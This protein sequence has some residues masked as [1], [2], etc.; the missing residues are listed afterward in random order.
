[1]YKITA[2]FALFFLFN[3]MPALPARA[4][5]EQEY[6]TTNKEDVQAFE[7][8]FG[9]G[10]QEEDVY[11]T[12]R[13]L[14][15]ATGSLKPIHLA[16]S[17]ASVITAEDIE[18]LGATTLDEV[19]ETVPG[20]HVTPS[21]AHL[22]AIY[23]IR[24]IHTSLNPQVLVL[25]NGI[26]FTKT[27][28]GTRPAGFR[29][30][31]SMISRIEVI[32]G[33]GSALYG[34]DAFAG[35]LNIITK[36]RFEV[37]KGYAGIRASSLDG[38]NVW[39]QHGEQYY[40]WDI[41]I[42]VEYWRSGSNDERIIEA[43]LQTKLDQAFG[44][45]ASLA[46]GFV[47]T[48][49]E[50]YNMANFSKNRWTIR[51]WG[52]F[53]NDY[54]GGTGGVDAL[55]PESKIN[56]EQFLSDI[57]WHGGNIIEDFDFTAQAHYLYRREDIIYQMLPPG[58]TVLVGTDGNLFTSPTAG[59][60]TFTDG[61]FGSPVLIDNEVSFDFISKYNGMNQHAWRIAVGGKLQDEDAESS[62]NFG[63][64]VLSNKKILPRT[65]DGDLVD[66]T[67]T[68]AMFMSDQN[69]TILHVSL[70]DEWSFTQDWEL[71]TG[72]RYDHYSDFGETI[73]PRV[74]LVWETRY[75]L[76]S[77]FM[78][79]RAFRPPSFAESSVR[80]NPIVSGNPNLDPETI[81]T[82]EFSIDYRPVSS[83]KS[84]LS[85]FAYDVEGLIDYIA[86]PAPATTKTARNSIDQKGHGFE[87]ELE[88][89]LNPS[90]QLKGNFA[91]QDSEDKKN[92][93]VVADAPG[94]Q[95]YLNANWN[96]MP[97]WYLTMQY[98]WI[99]DRQRAIDDN[100]KEIKDNSFANVLIRKKN[101]TQNVDLAFSVRNIFN[102][103]IRE[104]ISP[105]IPNDL[106]MENRSF[107]TE[108]IY[109]Y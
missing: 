60:I 14:L 8:M 23:S 50:N 63:P 105:D 102:E 73:N 21:F 67:G 58:T 44:T 107:Y 52:W 65:V 9:Q 34:A 95:C 75:D 48:D 76:T 93:E 87:V 51:L 36:D 53:L 16:P 33:P 25:L 92:G 20:L 10:P 28:N 26:P 89:E 98:F 54:E 5:S 46:P 62:K 80:N 12:D 68:D 109:H 88:W 3:N 35:T 79:G 2:T 72:L 39:A 38:M 82:Y 61:I 42:G 91:L 71:T 15:T 103:D 97:E 94:I 30:P 101:I 85:V 49:F 37:E 86:D 6:L 99:G 74:A 22:D 19:L 66:V 40:G 69:R 11:S 31:V 77:K 24:G 64:G 59:I 108:L 57:T 90:L 29:L 100:R 78:Y 83:F 104:P 43:D 96:F 17:V 27:Y 70:Q 106:P 1:M 47:H 81:D 56:S 45:N 32:R 84:I 18:R 7:E 55:G 13:L 41:G 4:E